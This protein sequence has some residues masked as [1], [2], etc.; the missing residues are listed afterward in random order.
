MLQNEM[1]LM[2]YD[3]KEVV[4]AQQQQYLHGVGVLLEGQDQLIVDYQDLLQ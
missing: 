4:V 3:L 2:I 1:Q